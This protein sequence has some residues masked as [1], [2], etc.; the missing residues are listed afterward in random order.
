MPLTYAL[1]NLDPDAFT[2]RLAIG[3]RRWVFGVN[4]W[5]PRVRLTRDWLAELRDGAKMV[6]PESD[7][8]LH[9]IATVCGPASEATNGLPVVAEGPRLE[10]V[11]ALGGRVTGGE[12]GFSDPD[13]VARVAGRAR[14][15]GHVD[16]LLCLN[17]DVSRFA[18]AAVRHR[19]APSAANRA[20]AI[21]LATRAAAQ[22]VTLIRQLENE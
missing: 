3:A 4:L 2:L 6:E 14:D 9:A 16:G 15:E 12:W 10:T 7:P 22:I 19:V 20:D 8:T 5:P 21:N 13:A 1:A 11:K 18:A 17:N